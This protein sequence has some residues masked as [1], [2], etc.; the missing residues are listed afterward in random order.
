VGGVSRDQS[1]S[2]GPLAG[3]GEQFQQRDAAL[4]VPVRGA[5]HGVDL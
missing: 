5:I 1:A 3:M 2:F 4:A